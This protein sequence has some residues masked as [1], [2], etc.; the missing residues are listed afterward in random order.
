MTNLSLDASTT[1]YSSRISIKG[2]FSGLSCKSR[3]FVHIRT[4]G[5]IAF[6]VLHQIIGKVTQYSEAARAADEFGT[7]DAWLKP[8][9]N[10][11]QTRTRRRLPFRHAHG[12]CY[13]CG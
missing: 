10:I 9:R 6:K 2:P 13:Q 11:K 4:I 5:K 1:A 3:Q 12:R 8:Q 7:S